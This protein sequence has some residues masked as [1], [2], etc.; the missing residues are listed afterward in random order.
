M[1]P[2]V[3]PTMLWAGL[4]F[5]AYYL[6]ASFVLQARAALKSNRSRV[7]LNA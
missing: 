6:I 7:D 5:I 1:L 2:A 4:S 3:N